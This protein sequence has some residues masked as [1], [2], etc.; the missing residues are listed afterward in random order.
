MKSG[1][2]GFNE[3]SANHVY[4]IY[5]QNIFTSCSGGNIVKQ[6]LEIEIRSQELESRIP[7]PNPNPVF[8]HRL[9]NL[10]YNLVR[11]INN[12]RAKRPHESK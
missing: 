9:L 5:K 12:N 2:Q 11:I 3:W 10:V 7:N 4:N 1:D 8:E 6:E